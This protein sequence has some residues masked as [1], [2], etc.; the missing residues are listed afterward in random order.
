MFR[1]KEQKNKQ[2]GFDYIDSNKHF[3]F[4]SA[5]QTLRP[6]EVIDAEIKYYREYNACGHR[7]KYRWGELVDEKVD[8]TRNMLLKLIGKSS[9]DYTVAFTLNT[10]FGINTVLHQINSKKYS[11]VTTSV[12]EHNSV[13]LPTITFANRNSLRRIVLTRLD[14]G[15]L[16]YKIEDIKN[17][18]VLLNTTSNIDGRNLNNIKQL[19]KDVH[20]QEGIVLL[21]ASQSFGHNIDILKDADF[22]AAFGSSHKMYGPSL[23]FIIIKKTLLKDLNCFFIGGST[24]QD[25]QLDSYELIENDNE[26]YSRIEPGLQNFAGIVGLNEAIKWKTSFSQEKL[27]AVEYE[28]NLQRYLNTGLKGI[29]SIKLLSEEPSSVV[30]IY[31]EKMDSH[32]MGIFLSQRNIMCRTGYHCCHYY[33]KNLK[34]YPPLFRISLGLHNTTEQIDYL[35]ESVN[36]LLR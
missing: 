18:I 24:V 14:D 25:V 3:Y 22:D 27:D 29:K 21:D 35:I 31:S 5:C 28:R 12:I 26:I 6:Q 4:D 34:K 19:V 30:S 17:S 13:F 2:V 23:G 36:I 15:S 8:E 16:D 1:K 32:R 20:N 7:V 33:L 10:T 11:Q 9:K